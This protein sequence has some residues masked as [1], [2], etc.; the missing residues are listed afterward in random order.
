MDQIGGCES[1]IKFYERLLKLAPMKFRALLECEFHKF[2]IILIFALIRLFYKA[3]FV[4]P[5]SHRPV[6]RGI[7]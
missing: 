5:S 3:P 2:K 1:A 7:I 6:V 4:N